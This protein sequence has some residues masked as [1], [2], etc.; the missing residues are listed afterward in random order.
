VEVHDRLADTVR[1]EG[2]RILATLVRTVGN[3]QVAEDA[4]QDAV[5]AA[6]R[7]WPRTGVP[8]QPRAW[9]TVTARHRAIDILRREAARAGKE[10]EGADLMELSKPGLPPE[11]TVRDD[12]LR[13]IFT[14][15]HPALSPDARVA[16]ALR[17]L[18][19][20]S[21]AQ[22]AAVLL[23]SE[24]AMAKRLTRTRQKIAAARIPY[25]VPPDA[26]LPARLAAVCGVVHALY[27]AGHAPV[28]G[29]SAVDVD[30]CAEAVRLARLLRDLLP[31]EPMPAAVLALLLLTD[32]RRPA[33]TDS[34]GEVVPL[35]DQDRCRWNA[36]LIAEGCALLDTSLRRTAGVADPYQLQAAI[37][38]EHA[39]A[40]SYAST[41][42]AEIV[43]LYDL[44]LSVA[45][46]PAA[47]LSRAVA[48]A[49]ASGTAA[50]LAT[51]AGIA[52]GPRWYAVRAEL[53]AREGRYAEAVEAVTVSLAGE[54][55]GPER[56]FRQRRRA[57]WA[58]QGGGRP[59]APP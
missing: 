58:A 59:D 30:V 35:A 9:L 15:C 39:R 50:G 34:A 46:T 13:L 18:C 20:L 44:L 52:P 49:E 41:D 28:G 42:W 27:T 51:L 43:R 23:S 32:A 37:A 5:L 45:A 3:L 21:P 31:D 6:L 24:P 56:R 19:G 29:E 14:C 11:S 57:E 12:Q 38:A 16:L 4:V 33:R 53:L 2:A 8:A 7:E 22:V 10:R 54:L 17:T 25:R 48:V 36:A 47:A 40:P 1:I 26:E 55:T